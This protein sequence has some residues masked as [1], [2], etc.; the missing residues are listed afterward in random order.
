MTKIALMVSPSLLKYGE[1]KISQKILFM[2]TNFAQKIYRGI[3]LHGGNNDKNI[4]RGERFQNVFSSN[5][6][7]VNLKI[8]TSHG[9]IFT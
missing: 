2:G 6:N 5:L 1:K 7:F 8:F 4:P 3:V 9:G